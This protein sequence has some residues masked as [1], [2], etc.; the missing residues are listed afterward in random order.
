MRVFLPIGSPVVG[1]G[2]FD[3]DLL[4]VINATFATYRLDLPIGPV[5]GDP[6]GNP[7]FTYA[8]T[9]GDLVLSSSVNPARQSTF[10]AAVNSDVPEPSTVGLAAVGMAA[11]LLRRRLK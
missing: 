11:L 7:T 4:N 10:T 1:I 3:S 2:S 8:T 6:A 9:A 5:T